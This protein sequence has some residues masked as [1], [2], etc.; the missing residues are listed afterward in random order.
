[1]V[2]VYESEE[3]QV[4]ALK[5]WWKE[6][7]TAVIVGAVLGFSILGG[8]N[9]WQAQQHQQAEQ[10]STLYSELLNEVQTNQVEAAKNTSQ[11]LINA[12]DD[13]AYADYARLIQSKLEIDA[14]DF[15]VAKELLTTQMQDSDLELQNVARIRLVRLMLANSEYEQGLQLI[16]EVNL[17]NSG[18]FDAIYD[19]LTGDLYVAL[20]RLGEART[21]YEKV[22]RSGQA[23]PLLQFKLDDITAPEIIAPLAN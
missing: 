11:S 6:N 4:E 16:S 3:A 10:A 12:H 19:E 5:A 2:E 17:A 9:F 8:W 22:L 7:G 18:S 23:S 15:V 21:A 1:M 14:G 13:L 20:D